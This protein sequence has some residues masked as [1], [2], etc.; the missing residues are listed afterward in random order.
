MP[1]DD[2]QTLL[3]VGDGPEVIDI[4]TSDQRGVID[5]AQTF[6]AV[7]VGIAID[8]ARCTMGPFTLAAIYQQLEKALKGGKKK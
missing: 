6:P 3:F 4:Y 5:A 7:Y 2:K 8:G 1:I